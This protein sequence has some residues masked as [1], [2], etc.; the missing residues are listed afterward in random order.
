MSAQQFELEQGYTMNKNDMAKEEH[1]LS[2]LTSFLSFTHTHMYSHSQTSV[3]FLSNFEHNEIHIQLRPAG[4]KV[5]VMH[6]KI[7]KKQFL[8]I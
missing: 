6:K 3:H 1:Y 4:I 5:M 2:S 7:P 8:E